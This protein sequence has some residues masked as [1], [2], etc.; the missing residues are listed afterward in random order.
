MYAYATG[1]ASGIALAGKLQKE[2]V[3]AQQAYLDMLRGGS[4]EPLLVLLKKAAVDL[5]RPDAVEVAMR[6]FART[7][8]EL[9]G[10]LGS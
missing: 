10:L 1:L 4:A 7:L 3:P 9:E 6:M 8:D 5:T 2:G